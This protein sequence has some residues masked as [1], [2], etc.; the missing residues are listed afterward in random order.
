VVVALFLSGI[1]TRVERTSALFDRSRPAG[2]VISGQEKKGS[3]KRE[4]CTEPKH[5]EIDRYGSCPSGIEKN[6]DF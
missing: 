6:K 5:G 4:V 1:F 3:A 2:P